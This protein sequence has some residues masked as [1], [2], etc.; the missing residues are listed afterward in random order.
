MSTAAPSR[1]VIRSG[2]AARAS[3]PRFSTN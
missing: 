1:S 3:S 2:P